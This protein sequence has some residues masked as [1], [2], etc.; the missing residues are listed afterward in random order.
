M[1]GMRRKK[2]FMGIKGVS[3]YLLSSFKFTP[4]F[5]FSQF[6]DIFEL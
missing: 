2:E 6:P 3:Q 5:T 4:P 1:T